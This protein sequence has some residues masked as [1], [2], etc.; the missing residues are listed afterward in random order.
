MAYG[1]TEQQRTA[2]TIAPVDEIDPHAYL[3]PQMRVLGSQNKA[4]GK[5][6]ALERDAETGGLSALTVR[7]GLFG[8]RFTSV[9][10]S[11]VKWVNSNSVILDY[12]PAAFKRISQLPAN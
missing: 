8:N 9:P 3:K 2:T 11:R 6:E 10:A 1:T 7:H 5:I 12:T 4:L